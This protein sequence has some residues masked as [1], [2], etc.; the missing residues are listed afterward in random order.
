MSFTKKSD[1]V[2]LIEAARVFAGGDGLRFCVWLAGCH[3]KNPLRVNRPWRE[4]DDA[5][6]ALAKAILSGGDKRPHATRCIETMRDGFEGTWI[7]GERAW[8]FNVS[9]KGSA[10][11]L[12][13]G[14]CSD[15]QLAVLKTYWRQVDPRALVLTN[16]MGF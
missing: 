1:R 16:D 4:T 8:Y 6:D 5:I 12:D 3:S 14:T 9:V 7:T 13:S 15:L 2:S 11:I 10:D